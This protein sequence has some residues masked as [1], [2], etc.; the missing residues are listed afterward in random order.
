MRQSPRQYQN[1]DLSDQRGGRDDPD[2]RYARG[3]GADYDRG[4]CLEDDLEHEENNMRGGRAHR[5]PNEHGEGHY[6]S[7]EEYG[8]GHYNS[9]EEDDAIVNAIYYNSPEEDGEG[10][11]NPP[12]E[13]DVI[14]NAIDI[15]TSTTAGREAEHKISREESDPPRTYAEVCDDSQ[16]KLSNGFSPTHN[17]DI[18]ISRLVEL[19]VHEITTTVAPLPIPSDIPIKQCLLKSTRTAVVPAAEAAKGRKPLHQ[20]VQTLNGKTRILDLQRRSV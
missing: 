16:V 7:P 17:E 2:C 19:P 15:I 6:N 13:D 11:C 3:S 14:V 9:L 1:Q 4:D 18:G 12:E 8:E 20:Q 5:P 10:H